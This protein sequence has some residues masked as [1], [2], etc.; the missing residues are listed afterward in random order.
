M[1]V[2][3]LSSPTGNPPIGLAITGRT[4]V[5]L[6]ALA[7]ALLALAALLLGLGGSSRIVAD[8]VRRRQLLA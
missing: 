3:V 2:V 7:A 5:A 6:L 8:R 4:I 1:P